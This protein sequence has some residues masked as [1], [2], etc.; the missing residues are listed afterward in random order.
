MDRSNGPR[1]SLYCGE[2]ILMRGPR[3]RHV[4]EILFDISDL[5]IFLLSRFE[6]F[7]SPF[8]FLLIIN[9]IE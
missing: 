2:K 8:R 7:V 3:V 5:D 4:R 9:S 6:R 1:G